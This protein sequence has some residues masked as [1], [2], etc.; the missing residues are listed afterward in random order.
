ML[1]KCVSSFIKNVFKQV[2][3]GVSLVPYIKLELKNTSIKY[4]IS[5]EYIFMVNWL[6]HYCWLMF[7]AVLE[8]GQ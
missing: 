6:A 2:L 4:M 1:I 7:Y 3:E 5:M 8:N